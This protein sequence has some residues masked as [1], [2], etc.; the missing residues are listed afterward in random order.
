M[1]EE[2]ST[3]LLWWSWHEVQSIGR[4]GR[5]HS[6][7]SSEKPNYRAPSVYYFVHCTFSL[8]QEHQ[9]RV[10]IFYSTSYWSK[11]TDLQQLK[12]T[13]CICPIICY[14]RKWCGQEQTVCRQQSIMARARALESGQPTYKPQLQ[15]LAERPWATY[16]T[17]M[18]LLSHLQNADNYYFTGVLLLHL[19]P[20][21]QV[22]SKCTLN[23]SYYWGHSSW[24]LTTSLLHLPPLL[25]LWH[26]HTD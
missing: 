22:H 10:I 5:H 14:S 9:M 19:L 4:S 13:T 8:I 17:F 24:G 12:V 3:W 1:K 20:Q 11:V 18:S 6:G 2:S 21:Y 15:H 26:T 7:F 16:S 25:S 23:V